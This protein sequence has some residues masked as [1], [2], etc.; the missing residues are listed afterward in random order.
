V[1]GR[2]LDTAFL[3]RTLHSFP[4]DIARLPLNGIYLLFERGEECHGGA[5]IVRV[6]THTGDRQLRS[7]VLQHFVK[8][9]KDRS[10]F[11]K[12][13][14]RALLSKTDDPYLT[15]WEHDRTSRT[16]RARYGEEPDAA[17]RRA[18][19]ADVTAYLRD[20]F[21]FVV[22]SVDE[23]SERLTLESR[24]IST[25]SHCEDCKPSA[26]WLALHSPRDRIRESG[27]WLVNELYKEPLSSEDVARLATLLT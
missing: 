21:A 20:R 6:G 10:I 4:F 2:S 1:R 11:R 8:Q 16:D 17:K 27:L 5:R 26:D 7:R 25:L 19:E 14:G 24:M 15:E 23:Q 18:V 9:N 13:I 12:N 22:F 3:D